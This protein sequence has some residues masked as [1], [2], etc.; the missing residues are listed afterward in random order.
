MADLSLER[1]LLLAELRLMASLD[2]DLGV[3]G[4]RRSI[5]LYRE[6]CEYESLVSGSCGPW[7]RISWRRAL[8]EQRQENQIRS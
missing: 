1:E 2:N 7:R 8:R 5:R 3:H 4:P 6:A